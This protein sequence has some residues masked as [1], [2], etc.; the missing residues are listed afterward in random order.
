LSA[1]VPIRTTQDFV[2][3]RELANVLFVHRDRWD[4]LPYALDMT[5]E[6]VV[7]LEPAAFQRG[8][9]GSVALREPVTLGAG[10][11]IVATDFR[12]ENTE[13][14][15]MAGLEAEGR[16]IFRYHTNT[17]FLAAGYRFW[18]VH[19]DRPM[20][21]SIFLRFLHGTSDPTLTWMGAKV[22]RIK[23]FDGFRPA[24]TG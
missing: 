16:E 19:L 12:A 8:D 22:V 2:H 1:Y 9:D 5:K 14:V 18:P 15:V 21:V 6:H 13:N 7:E 4:E 3:G 10:R 23:A 17:R 20:N 24:I 11:Y